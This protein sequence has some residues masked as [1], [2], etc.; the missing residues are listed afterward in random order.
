[1]H[2]LT[3]RE[4]SLYHPRYSP[5]AAVAAVCPYLYFPLIIGACRLWRTTYRGVSLRHST[6]GSPFPTFDTCSLSTVPSEALRT[7]VRSSTL[8]A[9]LKRLLATR[10]SLGALERFTSTSGGPQTSWAKHRHILRHKV[11][12]LCRFHHS[13]KAEAFEGLLQVSSEES[14]ADRLGCRLIH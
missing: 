11:T 12:P 4:Y 10:R 9:S 5:S 13:L 7:T 2:V 1:M 6:L 14:A 3:A 8:T